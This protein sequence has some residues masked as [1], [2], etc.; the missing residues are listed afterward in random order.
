MA[1]LG[2][3]GLVTG[4]ISFAV[5]V[6]NTVTR[7][8]D[9]RYAI[10]SL[11]DNVERFLARLDF[12]IE[13]LSQWQTKWYMD[14]NSPLSLPSIY[15][16][17]D[18]L[19]IYKIV[20]RIHKIMQKA[21]KHI[22][23]NG[24]TAAKKSIV[25]KRLAGKTWDAL[26]VMPYVK[27]DVKSIDEDLDLLE[28]W[29]ELLFKRRYNKASLEDNRR[30]LAF[31][32]HMVD[33]AECSFSYSVALYD[34]LQQSSE[35][36]AGLILSRFNHEIDIVD[37]DALMLAL[38]NKDFGHCLALNREEDEAGRTWSGHVSCTYNL[39]GV[40][41]SR[42]YGQR[43]D[44]ASAVN[45]VFISDRQ[46]QIRWARHEQH[47][48]LLQRISLEAREEQSLATLLHS[49]TDGSPHL[50]SLLASP[51]MKNE[52]YEL[53]YQLAVWTE[54]CLE[55]KWFSSLC[56]CHVKKVEVGQGF[57][58]IFRFDVSRP[59]VNKADCLHPD[60]GQHQI[61]RLGY[62]LYELGSGLPLQASMIV[63]E[64]EDEG[65]EVSAVAKPDSQVMTLEARRRLRNATCNTFVAAVEFCLRKVCT[66]S[67]RR[68]CLFDFHIQV[69]QA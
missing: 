40:E 65:E 34:M 53:A 43:D 66:Y 13:K 8:L 30:Q 35:I 15:W 24:T 11:P 41:T 37:A 39:N 36:N 51:F 4:T 22:L 33:F 18:S 49:P 16:G 19:R 1:E 25:S 42:E 60:L 48:F 7:I 47:T 69:T 20:A 62:L 26:F 27:E 5:T 52:R 10:Q 9:D 12:L 55:T 64:F 21:Y 14:E 54:L 59:A 58:D 61:R 23:P 29:S 45:D 2:I 63:D 28:N 68:E 50:E 3:I 44:F 38:R 57:A 17:S 32:E 6:R 67:S 56:S 31:C 46:R